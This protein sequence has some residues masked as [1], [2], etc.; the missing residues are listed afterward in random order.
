MKKNLREPKKETI[1]QLAK[2]FNVSAD[3]LLGH[4]DT[5]VILTPNDTNRYKKIIRGN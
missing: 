3:Y 4:T 2:L 5:R 1:S